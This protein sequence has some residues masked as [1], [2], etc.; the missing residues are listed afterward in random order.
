MLKEVVEQ[1]HYHT[2][3]TEQLWKIIAENY[4]DTFPNLM[5]LAQISLITPLNTADC[6]RGFSAQNYIFSKRRTSMLST[7]MNKLLMIYVQGP[8]I[9][10][11]T[12]SR[13]CKFTSLK[14]TEF[15]PTK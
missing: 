3:N 9:R 7:N 4:R 2:G 15:S 1:Q 6:E 14:R 10:V 11:L 13:Q 5:K 12:L 8:P